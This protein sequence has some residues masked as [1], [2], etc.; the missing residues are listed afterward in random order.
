MDREYAKG[1][2]VEGY[3]MDREYAKGKGMHRVGKWKGM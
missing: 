3:V 2:E 1:R